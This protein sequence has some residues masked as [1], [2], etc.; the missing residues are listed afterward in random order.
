M[1]D[2]C[3]LAE[4]WGCFPLIKECIKLAYS[5][6]NGV[7]RSPGSYSIFVRSVAVAGRSSGR[8]TQQDFFPPGFER[9]E[10]LS[11]EAAAP[12]R[13]SRTNESM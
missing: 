8:Y 9:I 6:I 3:S 11:A 1:D 10:S 5:E 2:T 12:V 4:K 13:D 7:L